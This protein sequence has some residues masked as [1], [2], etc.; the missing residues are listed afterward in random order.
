MP[1][2][3]T[4]KAKTDPLP[5]APFEYAGQWVAWN[6][7]GTEIVAHG[8]ELA[9]VHDAAIAAGHSD[10]VLEKVPKANTIF[11]SMSRGFSS[12]ALFASDRGR[13]SGEFH[14]ISA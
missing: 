3:T 13:H 4:R 9:A 10:C 2:S 6:K 8:R 5:A 12:S 14:E 11:I 1:K 7:E